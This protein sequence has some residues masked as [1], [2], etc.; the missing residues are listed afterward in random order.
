MAPPPQTFAAKNVAELFPTLVWIFDL[1]PADAAQANAAFLRQ[2]DAIASPRPAQRN[3]LSL[4]SDHNLQAHACFAPLQPKIDQAVRDIMAHLRLA[5]AAFMV[6]GAWLN[7]SVPG[8][9][10]HEHNHPNNFLSLV[11]YVRTPAGG[12]SIRFYD[13]RPQAHLVMPRSSGPSP[14]TAS[15]ITFGVRAGRLVAFPA[16]LR[17]SVDANAGA[18]ERVSVAVNVMF[19]QFA[20]RM[21]APLWEAKLKA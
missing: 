8:V 16:W 9:R 19:R 17:H 10:H 2:L 12:D 7:L 6:T 11:Y 20:E 3:D 21:A 1:P 4:Q 14:H 15:S 5:D 18:G 13:P